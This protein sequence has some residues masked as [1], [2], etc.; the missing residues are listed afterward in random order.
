M[1]ATAEPDFEAM[2]QAV[3]LA[4]TYVRVARLRVS[5]LAQPRL[6]KAAW[7]AAEETRDEP[8]GSLKPVQAVSRHYDAL[9]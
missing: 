4:Q 3:A 2:G 9:G 5:S 7:L 1:T 8:L 6:L